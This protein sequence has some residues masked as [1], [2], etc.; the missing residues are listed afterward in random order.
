MAADFV[1]V[2]DL[3]IPDIKVKYESPQCLKMN[4]S[5]QEEAAKMKMTETGSGDVTVFRGESVKPGVGPGVLIGETKVWRNGKEMITDVERMFPTGSTISMCPEVSN[6]TTSISAKLWRA[7]SSATMLVVGLGA[8]FLLTSANTTLVH[9]R[10]NI[11]KVFTS[12]GPVLSVVNHHSCFDDPGI[13]GAVLS[14]SQLM[15]TR[16]MRWGASASEVIF[17]NKPLEMF[18]KLGKVI[19]IVR[20]W[21]VNQPAM[22]FLLDKLN[23]GGWVNIFPEGKVT[24]EDNI[25]LLRWGVGRLVWDCERPPAL[26]PVLHMGMDS[27]LP[28]PVSPGDSQPCVLRPGNLV[29]VNIG[30]P[31]DMGPVVQELRTRKVEA[32]E[33]R[34][35]ITEHVQ[36]VMEKMYQETKVLHRQNIVK[37]L[38]RWHDTIDTTPSIMT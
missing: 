6:S 29:T 22:Q 2:P 28:N 21:G 34:R 17:I 4:N 16:R 26:V 25:G 13:W 7:A 37:W 24:V 15:D 33:A 35:M 32:V 23:R 27:I 12:D 31:L 38:R 19:P 5:H 11:D 30:Q 9:G 8:K 36:S 18:W 20:G 1:Q 10:E 14:P 3:D